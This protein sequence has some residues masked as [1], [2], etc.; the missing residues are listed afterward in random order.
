MAPL[1][2]RVN[3]VTTIAEA[4]APDDIEKDMKYNIHQTYFNR[5]YDRFT[6]ETESLNQRI[7]ALVAERA[8][9]ATPL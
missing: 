2:A 3:A 6:Q 5:Q 7:D 9:A 8:A 4:D 1:I